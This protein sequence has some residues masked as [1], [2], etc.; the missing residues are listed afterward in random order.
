[1]SKPQR[2]QL[3]RTK[4]WRMP[5]NTV[6][7]TRPSIWGNPF[8][9]PDSAQ[10]VDAYRR[11]VSGGTQ[12]FEMGPGKLQFAHNCHPNTLHWAYANYV[13]EHKQVLRGKNLAC[14]CPIGDPCHADVLLE[15]ANGDGSP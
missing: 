2:I 15:I 14:W 3:R 4:G 7:V 9:H 12:S 10:A 13:K 1:V 5:E 6:K 11:L 8:V